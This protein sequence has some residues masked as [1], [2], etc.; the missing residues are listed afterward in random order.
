M[1]KVVPYTTKNGITKK[2]HR[3]PRSYCMWEFLIPIDCSTQKDVRLFAPF[4]KILA[5]RYTTIFNLL[6]L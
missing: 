2:F 3:V 6:T 1:S 5:I 4:K